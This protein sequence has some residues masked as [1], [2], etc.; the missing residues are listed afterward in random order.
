MSYLTNKNLNA[1][2]LDG[3]HAGNNAG[4]IPINNGILNTN[5]N[6]DLLDGKH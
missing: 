6:A 5:L 1:D 2:L 4:E 3:K